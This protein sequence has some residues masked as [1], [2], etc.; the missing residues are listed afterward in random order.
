MLYLIDWGEGCN[1]KHYMLVEATT[2]Q[3]LWDEVDMIGDPYTVRYTRWRGGLSIEFDLGREVE[4]DGIEEVTAD[5]AF[6]PVVAG[7]TLTPASDTAD[8]MAEHAENLIAKAKWKTF[9]ENLT[10]ADPAKQLRKP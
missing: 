5:T 2:A 10:L 9:A 1:G 7:L 4:F 6:C 3:E 8:L